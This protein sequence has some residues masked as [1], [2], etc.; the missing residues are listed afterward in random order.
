M[1]IVTRSAWG[2]EAPDCT[3]PVP[4]IRVI[5]VH[6][7]AADSDEQS[8]HAN[9]ASRVKGIQR[10]HM[11]TRGWCDIAY[12]FLVCKHGFIFTGRGWD[13]RSGATG[14]ANDFSIA[15]CFLGDDTANR[16]DVTDEGRAAL[17]EF[18]RVATGV[19]FPGAAVKGHRDFMSTACPG[20]ELYKFVTSGAWKT[21]TPED[22]VYPWLMD[23]IRWYL[24]DRDE[25]RPSGVPTTI[26][27]DAWD[28]LNAVADLLLRR[29]S[30][31]L[32]QAWRDWYDSG[33]DPN[34]RPAVP[35]T[36]FDEWWAARNRDVNYAREI[37]APPAP[38]C[39]EDEVRTAALEAV[40]AA[41]TKIVSA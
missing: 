11:E 35:S 5:A 14:D 16:D 18:L 32:Y 10:F 15:I 41:R 39:R 24:F 30:H 34:S 31:G 7:S 36:V 22:E 33:R 12:N 19:K 38:E 29:G 21:T 6:Y 1:K 23:W 40:D 4:A 20:N 2:A 17:S 27:A 8:N 25:P 26:P 28:A 13:N 37:I 3:S 9:C